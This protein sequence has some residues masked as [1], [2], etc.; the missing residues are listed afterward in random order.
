M[1]DQ[2]EDTKEDTKEYIV[3][4]PSTRGYPVG[5]RLQLTEEQAKNLV[6]K[7]RLVSDGVPALNTDLAQTIK[8]LADAQAEIKKLKAELAKAKK[9]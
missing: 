6:N 1:A 7:V 2:K 5:H 8:D 9:A 4:M 3:T